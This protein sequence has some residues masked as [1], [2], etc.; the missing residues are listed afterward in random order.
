MCMQKLR[1]Q[2][3][4]AVSPINAALKRASVTA[5]LKAAGKAVAKHKMLLLFLLPSFAGLM[6]F[7]VLPF[8]DVVRRSFT[9]SMGNTWVGLENYQTV[10][11][12]QAFQLAAGNTALFI[13]IS[14][15]L[16]V[17]S[18]LLVAL[19]IRKQRR[20]KDLFKAGF[21]LPLVIPVAAVALLWQLL[22]DYSG[23]LNGI[24]T[25]LGFSAQSWL[26]S[27]LA[28]WVLVGGYLW[29]NLG[30]SVVLWLVAL[31]GISPSLYEA[32]QLDGAG[33]W[34]MFKRIT[35]P[36]VSPACFTIVVLALINSFKVFREAFLVAGSY[37]HE[38]MYTVQHLFNNW[39]AALSFD[40]ISAGATLLSIVLFVLI[41]LLSKAWDL[42]EGRSQ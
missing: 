4:K 36:L 24:F 41:L 2:K 20:F 40:K 3:K 15:P 7:F 22:F 42:N 12:N 32:A 33:R 39:F 28:F 17:A 8:L 9:Q 31:E 14:I 13:F 16:L 19:F 37:P 27:P 23:I 18:S 26:D 35:L 25:S 21:L 6:V 34:A 30:F 1:G 10:L 11:S 5:R 38:S 29:R